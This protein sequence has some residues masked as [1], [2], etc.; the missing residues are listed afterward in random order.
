MRVVGLDESLRKLGWAVEWAN[1]RGDVIRL[2]GYLCRSALKRSWRLLH[3]G[4]VST[5]LHS[6]KM[7]CHIFGIVISHYVVFKLF[8]LYINSIPNRL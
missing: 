7:S 1:Q 5:V 4:V 6:S 2:V 8:E 3:I